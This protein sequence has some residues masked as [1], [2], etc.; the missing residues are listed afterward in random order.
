MNSKHF[1][2]LFVCDF[3]KHIQNYL[4]LHSYQ[5]TLGITKSVYRYFIFKLSR[6]ILNLNIISIASRELSTVDRNRSYEAVC[7]HEQA[8]DKCIY[9]WDLWFDEKLRT[10]TIS[11]Q[12]ALV[13]LKS[14][15][16]REK[17]MY[18]SRKINGGCDSQL[19]FFWSRWE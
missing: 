15:N 18:W 7:Q 14:T 5:V 12:V 19:D 16:N 1:Q 9:L 4:R 17:A 3:I 13:W 10:K 11:R 8:N 2:Q 6:D